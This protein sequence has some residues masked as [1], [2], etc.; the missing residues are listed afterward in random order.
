MPANFPFK[1]RAHILL[2]YK[3]LAFV[4]FSIACSK[5]FPSEHVDR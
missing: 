3:N 1:N 5:Y 4:Q 2:A